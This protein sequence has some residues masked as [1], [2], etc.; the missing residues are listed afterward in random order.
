[1]HVLKTS[2]GNKSCDKNL[3]FYLDHTFNFINKLLTVSYIIFLV[4]EYTGGRHTHI[5]IM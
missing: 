5:Y 1:M 4:K 3:S 2:N